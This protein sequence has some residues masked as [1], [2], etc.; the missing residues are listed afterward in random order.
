MNPYVVIKIGE[1]TF[2]SSIHKR[3]GKE[4]KWEDTYEYVRES[5]EVMDIEVFDEDKLK[6]DLVGKG[7]YSLGVL[8]GGS[9]KN[10]AGNIPIYYKDKPS[11]EVFFEIDFYPSGPSSGVPG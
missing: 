5:E 6:D 7:S 8:C 2:K 11:G 4:P 3:G 10:F 9:M 1:K